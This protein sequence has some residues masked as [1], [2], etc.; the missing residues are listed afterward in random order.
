MRPLAV[1]RA[2]AESTG[3]RRWPGIGGGPGAVGEDASYVGNRTGSWMILAAGAMRSGSRPGGIG[4]SGRGEGHRTPRG[5]QVVRQAQQSPSLRPAAPS[6]WG[7][8]RRDV[9]APGSPRGARH[10]PGGWPCRTPRTRSPDP[11]TA[12][13]STPRGTTRRRGPA[14]RRCGAGRRPGRGPAGWGAFPRQRQARG[15]GTGADAPPVSGAVR[16]ASFTAGGSSCA[17]RCR[18]PPPSSRR[19]RPGRAFS[20]PGPAASSSPAGEAA[21]PGGCREAP[22]HRMGTR[23]EGPH[24]CSPRSA[25]PRHVQE[26][27]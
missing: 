6:S 19:H 3:A 25:R 12:R 11:A 20:S 24:G 15:R 5:R 4:I 2:A 1:S 8:L 9:P 14:D 23:P 21:T 27:P 22:R 18:P 26:P 16:S 10:S 13:R 7:A 17:G